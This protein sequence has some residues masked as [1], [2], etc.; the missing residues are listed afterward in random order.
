VND[1]EAAAAV[2]AD[3]VLVGPET[4][5]QLAAPMPPRSRPRQPPLRPGLF[6]PDATGI[7]RPGDV[8]VISS[9]ISLTAEDAEM[10]RTRLLAA[11]PGITD[12][13][14]VPFRLEAIYRGD[15]P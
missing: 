12:I 10:W 2:L 9:N 8:L 11:L 6:N 7:A 13:V 15:P 5:P 14:I 3:A 4:G 1:S